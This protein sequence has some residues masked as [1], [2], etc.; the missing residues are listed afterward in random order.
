MTSPVSPSDPVFER[1]GLKFPRKNLSDPLHPFFALEY[2]HK[3]LCEVVGN[4]D[5]SGRRHFRTD[6]IRKIA[7]QMRVHM[8][9]FKIVC[10]H[11]IDNTQKIE[12]INILENQAH[13]YNH[14]LRSI[15]RYCLGKLFFFLSNNF[16]FI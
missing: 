2:V 15:V 11:W 7:E 9:S 13:L 4:A 12:F 3:I 1:S 6:D 10:P 5:G 8:N 16:K 14:F